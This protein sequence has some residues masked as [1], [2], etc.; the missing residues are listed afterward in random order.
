M[1]RLSTSGCHIVDPMHRIDRNLDSDVKG[2]QDEEEKH[3]GDPGRYVQRHSGMGVGE[4][5]SGTSRVAVNDH[6][7][8]LLLH[9]LRAP[10]E[11]LK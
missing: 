1:S 9:G 2:D 3:I 5:D 10:L 7:R 6:L 11:S 8:R 4:L